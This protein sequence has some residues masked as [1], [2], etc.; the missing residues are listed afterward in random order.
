MKKTTIDIKNQLVKDIKTSKHCG[1]WFYEEHILV[2]EK[3]AMDLCDKHPEANREAVTLMVW[4]HDIGRAHGHNEGHDLYGADYARKI[5]SDNGFDQDLI[6][7]VVDACK[8]HS[9]DDNGK[10]ES[11]EGK[12]L[13]TADALSHFHNGFYLRIL[14]SW[15]RKVNPERYPELAKKSD[16]QHLKKKLFLKIDRDLNEKIFF[17]EVRQK[18]MP[19]Y[20]AWQAIIEEVRL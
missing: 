10:P 9:C 13:A 8:T 1:A 4:F 3:L 12:I 2:V 20:E 14:I 6:D 18:I 16:Y 7:L 15:S 17:E 11:L 19:M 5:L